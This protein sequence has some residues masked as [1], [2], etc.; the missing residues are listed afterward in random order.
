MLTSKLLLHYETLLSRHTIETLKQKRLFLPKSNEPSS[1]RP[2]Y[3]L[4]TAGKI[5]EKIVGDRIGVFSEGDR[6]LSDKQYGFRKYRSAVDA[7]DKLI[8]KAGNDTRYQKVLCHT[9]KKVFCWH[10]KVLLL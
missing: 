10:S 6:G 1:Y 2:I 5:L 9:Q 3:L 8:G 7:I 4:D